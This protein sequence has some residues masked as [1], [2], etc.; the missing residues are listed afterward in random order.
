MK[1]W[2][3]TV[4]DRVIWVEEISEGKMLQV[5]ATFP[6]GQWLRVAQWIADKHNEAMEELTKQNEEK[7]TNT[8]TGRDCDDSH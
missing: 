3:V 2:E 7:N 6:H 1:R 4:R 8:T 5:I